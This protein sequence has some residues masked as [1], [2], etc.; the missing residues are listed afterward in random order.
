MKIVQRSSFTNQYAAEVVAKPTRSISV[1]SD[2]R[3]LESGLVRQGMYWRGVSNSSASARAS[4]F[5]LSTTRERI[6]IEKWMSNNRDRGVQLVSF[7]LQ[8]NAAK[9][10]LATLPESEITHWLRVHLRSAHGILA[11]D[12]TGFSDPYCD[13]YVLCP[14]MPKC[15]HTWCS[16]TKMQTLDPRWDETQRVPLLTDQALLHLMIWDWDRIG[17][18]DFLGE[19]LV[20]LTQ[21]ADGRTHQLTLTLDQYTMDVCPL[22]NRNA[23]VSGTVVVELQ[24]SAVRA[25]LRDRKPHYRTL[26]AYAY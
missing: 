10:M 5:D 22:D 13:L 8:S 15:K 19:C 4:S 2:A 23:Q 21:Y 6:A 17:G 1:V 9:E 16:S 11:A 24:I 25:T 18:D 14:S 26:S 7:T 12:D 20:D 3:L